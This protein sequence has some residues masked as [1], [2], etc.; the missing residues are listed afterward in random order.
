M[1]QILFDDRIIFHNSDILSPIFKFS[2]NIEYSNSEHDC[3]SI[4]IELNKNH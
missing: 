4:D 2:S 1:L 3:I